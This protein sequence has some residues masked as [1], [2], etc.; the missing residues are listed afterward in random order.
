MPC[1]PPCL[2]GGPGCD[3]GARDTRDADDGDAPSPADASDTS[4]ASDSSVEVGDTRGDVPLDGP[5]IGRCS[6]PPCVNGDLCEDTCAD[7]FGTGDYT[8][9]C[10][11]G[12]WVQYGG[13]G[14]CNPPHLDAAADIDAS[15]SD[16]D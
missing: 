14:T 4:D 3:S 13:V 11:D 16:S 15:A 7:T 12:A 5:F 8:R 1:N 10:I 9:V 6:P 2:F